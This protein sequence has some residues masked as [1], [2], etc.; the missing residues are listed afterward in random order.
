MMEEYET[1]AGSNKAKERDKEAAQLKEAQKNIKAERKAAALKERQL[2]DELEYEQARAGKKKT[3]LQLK[4]DAQQEKE[5][6]IKAGT[7]E[8]VQERRRRKIEREKQRELKRRQKQFSLETKKL[9]GTMFDTKVKPCKKHPAAGPTGAAV[10]AA[11]AAAAAPATP[12]PAPA[13]IVHRIP[14]RLHRTLHSFITPLH[15]F[16]ALL[17]AFT[18][19]ETQH[20]QQTARRQRV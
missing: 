19:G 8:E 3:P 18:A 5:R 11:A 13:T 20:Q 6:L 2:L 10:A 4:V 15:S 12:P 16:A 17:H 1:N 9:L 7:W 14:T